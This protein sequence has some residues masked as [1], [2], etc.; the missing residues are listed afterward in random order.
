MNLEV[1]GDAMGV[2]PGDMDVREVLPS[3]C[4]EVSDGVCCPGD[5]ACWVPFP[6]L[7]VWEDACCG[8]VAGGVRCQAEAVWPWACWDV[9]VAQVRC[10]GYWSPAPGGCCLRYFRDVN[11]LCRVVVL[12]YGYHCLGV[13][14][15]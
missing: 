6:D 7:P 10:Q 13:L 15:D 8:M 3:G 12:G 11:C 9:T 14:P 4:R 5:W 1:P 2:L